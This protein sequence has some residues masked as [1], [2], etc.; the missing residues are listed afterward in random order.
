MHLAGEPSS[1]CGTMQCS[2][3]SMEDK[4]LKSLRGLVVRSRWLRLR[5]AK[6]S[7]DVEH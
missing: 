7:Q 6:V 1:K 3:V 5:K 2:G 4:K